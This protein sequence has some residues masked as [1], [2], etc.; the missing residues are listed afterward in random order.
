MDYI[1][2][3]CTKVVQSEDVVN[4][5]GELVHV[6]SRSQSPG[7]TRYYCGPLEKDDG[8]GESGMLVGVR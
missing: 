5:N 1:C 7:G 3:A 4:N 8:F 6:S 2:K